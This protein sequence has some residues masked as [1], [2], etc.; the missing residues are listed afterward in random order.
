MSIASLLNVFKVFR[1]EELNPEERKRLV[2]EALL[3]TLARA[4]SS[5]S[6]IES[7]EVS[8]IQR[9]IQEAIDVEISEADIRVAA[10]S[11]LFETVSLDTALGRLS[12]RLS[13]DDRMLVITK[14]GDDIRSDSRVSQFELDYFDRVVRAL[15]VPPSMLVGMKPLTA[16]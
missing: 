13:D 15:K 12:S 11:E 8:A 5:D 6:H 3:L 16:D 10:K 2:Q 7:I 1:G 4:S 14:L 9:A